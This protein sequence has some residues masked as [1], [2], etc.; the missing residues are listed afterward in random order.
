M[1]RRGNKNWILIALTAAII[2]AGA[3]LSEFKSSKS[4]APA[5]E[6]VLAIRVIDGDTIEIEGGERVRYLGIDTPETTGPRKLLQCFGREASERNKELVEGKY[7]R[8]EKDISDKDKY[9]RLLRYVYVD[10]KFVNLELVKDGFA[11]T[12]TIPPDVKYQDQL[13]AGEREARESKR[14]L[15]RECLKI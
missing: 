7:V 3:S 5:T 8:L 15:W 4:D 10:D 2:L 9:N 14:G 12:L 13:L 1:S 6:K 11:H